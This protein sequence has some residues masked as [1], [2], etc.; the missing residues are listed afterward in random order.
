MYDMFFHTLISD[1]SGVVYGLYDAICSLMFSK[2]PHRLTNTQ[3]LLTNNMN[4]K[5]KCKYIQ[6]FLFVCLKI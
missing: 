2:N 4:F 1:L 6:I 3:T 5:D